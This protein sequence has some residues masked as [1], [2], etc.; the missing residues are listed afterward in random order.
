M[1][2]GL[3]PGNGALSPSG[4]QFLLSSHAE[5]QEGYRE[6]ACGWMG[7]QDAVTLPALDPALRTALGPKPVHATKEREA[8]SLAIQAHG[9]DQWWA[10]RGR[11]DPTSGPPRPRSKPRSQSG[12]IG[13][14]QAG[15]GAQWM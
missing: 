5:L 4:S 15:T 12:P 10:G 11:Q 1:W 7:S 14:L 6:E 3:R 2:S 13:S 8:S 9:V